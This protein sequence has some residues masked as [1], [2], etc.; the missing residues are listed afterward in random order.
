MFLT[1]QNEKQQKSNAGPEEAETS[2]F[3]YMFSPAAANAA[4][5][6]TDSTVQT[7][8][9][10]CRGRPPERA[11]SCPSTSPVQTL[12][13]DR[14]HVVT[15]PHGRTRKTRSERREPSKRL[16]LPFFS[17]QWTFRGM[18]SCALS[19]SPYRQDV[20]AKGTSST[21]TNRK[22]QDAAFLCQPWT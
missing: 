3:L 14:T 21:G 17:R 9:T 18:K 20:R 12:C 6:V 16:S 13:D 22:P 1:D 4:P 11:A 19:G 15:E 10:T 7:A 8:T 2:H 5:C